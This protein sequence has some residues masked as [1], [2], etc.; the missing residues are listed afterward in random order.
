MFFDISP[1]DGSGDPAVRM[2]IAAKPL[3][4]AVLCA[5]LDLLS[6]VFPD[7][8]KEGA[9]DVDEQELLRIVENG[10]IVD[11][12]AIRSTNCV[13]TEVALLIDLGARLCGRPPVENPFGGQVSADPQ[14]FD[15]ER[16]NI[17]LP[18]PDGWA[19]AIL[20]IAAREVGNGL[21]RKACALVA[22]DAADDNRFLACGLDEDTI[23]AGFSEDSLAVEWDN[24]KGRLDL[25]SNASILIEVGALLSGRRL[26]VA[27]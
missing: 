7:E 6:F 15:R 17:E 27:G 8:A 12:L 11:R 14:F 18:G 22:M 1:A 16:I 23:C 20:S 10:S 13:P 9:F 26:R 5:A 3:G 4:Q 2:T 21:L 24:E 25:G 19:D